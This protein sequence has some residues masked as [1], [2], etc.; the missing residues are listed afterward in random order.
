MSVCIGSTKRFARKTGFLIEYVFFFSSLVSYFSSYLFSTL[1]TGF[2]FYP[3]RFSF[4]RHFVC[5]VAQ[6]VSMQTNTDFLKSRC[7]VLAI[8]FFF[9]LFVVLLFSCLIRK[10]DIVSRWFCC[11]VHLK[12]KMS[13]FENK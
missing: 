13:V 12:R 10:Y 1:G 6:F 4:D 3:I 5:V 2:S 9:F 7:S 11:I 8:V